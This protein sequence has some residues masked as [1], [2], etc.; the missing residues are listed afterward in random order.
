MRILDLRPFYV[1]RFSRPGQPPKSPGFF[2]E[3][4][5]W[6]QAQVMA[7]RVAQRPA[8]APGPLLVSVGNLALGGTGKTP[9]VMS[10]AEG[11]AAL[12]ISGAILT[13]G[14][15]SSLGGPLQVLPDNSAAGDEARMMAAHLEGFGWPVVQARQ[16]KAGL[17]FLLGQAAGYQIILLEDAHQTGGLPRDLD[18][19]ILDNWKTRESSEGW[20]LEPATGSVFPFGPWRESYRGAERAEVFLIEEQ[21][22]VSLVGN[23]GQLVFAF[24]RETKLRQVRGEEVSAGDLK[25]GVVSGIAR[26]EKLEDAIQGML[27]MVVL[28][29]R[30]QDH[31]PYTR[32]TVHKLTAALDQAGAQG[33][34]TTEKDWVKL[35][36]LWE[37]PRPVLVLDLELKWQ[38][39][40][41]LLHY[42]KERVG[43]AKTGID[44]SGSTAP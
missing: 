1:R 22:H 33:L 28:S 30:C 34:V 3:A 37:D 27:A 44:Q 20:I 39:K 5:G 14:Y 25:W 15:G 18:L 36:S 29:V 42:L 43:E 32:A 6:L 38:Q 40:N 17:D 35:S 13:R 4:L 11:L 26:P 12:G 24:S 7:R 41:A 10:L 23:R 9:V 21:A 2:G 31:V 8:V 19:V 16:R